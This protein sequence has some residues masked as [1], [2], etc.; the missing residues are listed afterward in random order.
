MGASLLWSN[1]LSPHTKGA[2]V[3]EEDRGRGERKHFS[4]P[5]CLWSRRPSGRSTWRIPLGGQSVTFTAASPTLCSCPKIN[6]NS[7]IVS[8]RESET[9]QGCPLHSCEIAAVT[10][11]RLLSRP[12]KLPAPNYLCQWLIWRWCGDPG[13]KLS[14]LCS[15][16]IGS[17]SMREPISLL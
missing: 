14:R 16:I 9:T 13:T 3:T 2:I 11:S 6:S 7:S 15:H 4:V 1:W 8:Q 5:H 17:D 10:R 12:A